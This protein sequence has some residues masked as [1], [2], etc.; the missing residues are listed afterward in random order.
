VVFDGTGNEYEGVISEVGLKSATIKIMRRRTLSAK[1]K[2]SIILIQA[3]PKRGRMDWIVE[4]STELGVS[5]IVP[6][7]TKR[8]IVRF[9]PKRRS[10]KVERWRRISVEAAKQ[11]GR[12]DIPGVEEIMRF[13]DILKSGTFSGRAIMPCLDPRT[14]IIQDA[15]EAAACEDGY[16]VIIGPEGGFTAAEITAG[17]KRGILPVSL[18]QT[19]LRSETAAIM[20]ISLIR[21]LCMR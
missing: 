8:T 10:S 6:V 9:D 12:T 2:V 5:R 20:A 21:S 18:G 3:I 14:R 4:K 11:C 13:E 19:V 7:V 17:A 16:S 1:K 15:L